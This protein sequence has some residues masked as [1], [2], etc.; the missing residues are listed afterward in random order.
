MSTESQLPVIRKG[1]PLAIPEIL[2]NVF[3]F[4]PTT[5]L[6]RITYV[7]KMWRLEAR[8]K[9][10][11]NRN[12]IIYNSLKWFLGSLRINRGIPSLLKSSVTKSLVQVTKFRLTFNINLNTE[13]F[14]IRDELKDKFIAVEAIYDEKIDATTEANNLWLQDPGDTE[15]YN[16]FRR[17]EREV[18]NAQNKLEYAIK[19]FYDFEYFLMYYGKQ[20]GMLN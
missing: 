10:Y 11:Q 6:V 7:N 3:R 1:H 9:L 19:E 5:A 20:I 4:L 12:E 16:N 8:Q 18:K 2:A 14:A 15:K 17:S 13:L